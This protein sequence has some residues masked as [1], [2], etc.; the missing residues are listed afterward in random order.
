MDQPIKTR[1]NFNQ[2][3][4][5]N[6]FSGFCHFNRSQSEY[7]GKWNTVQ[8]SEPC[9]RTGKVVETLWTDLKNLEKELD[10]RGKIETTQTTA[11]L[12][13]ARIF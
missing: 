11:L 10:I 6:L 12:K 1:L 8:I 2:Q 4:E 7:E 9:Q 3:E 13:S 5:K